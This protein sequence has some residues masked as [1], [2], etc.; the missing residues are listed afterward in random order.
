VTRINALRTDRIKEWREKHGWSQRE[1][2]RL[3]GL[4]EAQINKYEKGRTDPSATFLKII[5]ET[6]GVSS[7]Y[8]LGLS[9]KPNGQLGD[10]LKPEER[11]LLD[12]Y[13]ANDNTTLLEMITERMRQT[14]SK[15]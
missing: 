5:A 1:L 2:G 10:T 11:Q 13:V 15:S 12:A 8:L 14:E 6:L 7:D 9:D 3:C 4:A